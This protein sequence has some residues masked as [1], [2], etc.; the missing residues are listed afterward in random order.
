MIDYEQKYK[1]AL[2]KIKGYVLDDTGCTCI[3][4]SDIFPELQEL[5]DDRI[6]K[7]I[8]NYLTK[9]W[10]NSQ[11]DVCGVHV[12][13]AIAWIE[14]QGEQKAVN[15]SEPKFKVTDWVVDN[16]GYVW[17]IEGIL[18]KLYIL[19][20]IDG[21]K[22]RPTI[23]W[24]NKTFH[25]WDIT[26][27]ANDGDVLS[28]KD[29]KEC[30][31]LYKGCLDPNHPN[32]PVAYGGICSG[33]N[34]IPGGKKFNNWWTDKKVYPATKE[35]RDKLEKSMADDGFTFD[36]DKK[37]LK[38]TNSYCQENC[39]GYQE[40]GKCF[41]D[42]D[43][44][45]KIEAEQ[46]SALSEEDEKIGKELIDFCEKCS[47][48]QTVI[49][50]QNDFTRWTDWLKSIKERLQSQNTWKPSD[51]QMR[52]LC[53]V[54]NNSTGNIYN[55]LKSL[56]DDLKKLNTITYFQDIFLKERYYAWKPSDEQ[57]EAF[58]HFVRSIGESGHASPYENNTKLLYSLLEQL[59]KL[60]EE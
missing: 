3:K 60:R 25:L 43:C 1:D 59:K 4:P 34:F 40:T 58:E 18:N 36:F 14:K 38:K 10:G 54:L 42:G 51:E 35:Q 15:E 8:L 22:S 7:A 37:E 23:E 44:K 17:R 52:C 13:D 20:G 29:D 19:E 45:A 12:E 27:D 56:F 57:I 50:S 2:S 47:Q 48:G 30:P 28:F 41:A 5:D 49:N 39:K 16:C 6:R 21:C 26:K 46:N 32:S 55:I 24:V 11:D 53:G 31:F 9:M 33:G